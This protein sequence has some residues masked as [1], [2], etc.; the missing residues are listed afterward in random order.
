MKKKLGLGLLLAVLACSV[1][2]STFGA[3]VQTPATQSVSLKDMVTAVLAEGKD[4]AGVY[5]KTVAGDVF[6]YALGYGE[7]DAT[8]GAVKFSPYEVSTGAGVLKTTVEYASGMSYGFWN[9]LN[10]LRFGKQWRDSNGTSQTNGKFQ[11][12]I[13]LTCKQNVALSV[14]HAAY[15]QPSTPLNTTIHFSVYR[16]SGSVIELLQ[17]KVPAK[18]GAENSPG[19]CFRIKAGQTIYYEMKRTDGW[20]T[21]VNLAGLWPTFTAD[22]AGYVPVTRTAKSLFDDI[23]PGTVA[24][25]R[26]EAAFSDET[27]YHAGVAALSGNITLNTATPPTITTL[28]DVTVASFRAFDKY[29]NNA[30]QTD[31][32]NSISYASVYFGGNDPLG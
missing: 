5:G 30:L 7:V 3:A 31:A 26:G 21:S 20:G 16:Q 24:A 25:D 11:A 22:P 29:A 15:E 14:T 9:N 1:C 19:G 23:L 13:R 12:I 6:D 27:T 17:D 28:S 10:T 18:E 4:E 32:K 8:A 2:A